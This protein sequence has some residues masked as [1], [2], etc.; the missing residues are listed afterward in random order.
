MRAMHHRTLPVFLALLALACD[1]PEP[2]SLEI[3][4]RSDL[5]A[6][7][8]AGARLVVHVAPA[9]S[10]IDAADALDLDAASLAMGA[11]A[12]SGGVLLGA[13]D[14]LLPG[15]YGVA[16]DLV[17]AGETVRLDVLA[18]DYVDEGA[19]QVV[20]TFLR[21]GEVACSDGAPCAE[22]P[23]ATAQ[24]IDGACFVI[25][26]ADHTDACECDVDGDCPAAEGCGRAVCDAHRCAIQPDDARC[27]ATESC[28]VD[29]H[30]D[31]VTCRGRAAG[32][33]CRGAANACDAPE[34]CPTAGGECPPDASRVV[35]EACVDDDSG[36]GGFC[37]VLTADAP[38]F[39]NTR[40]V[41]DEVCRVGCRTGRRVCTGTPRC[42][43][44]GGTIDDGEVCGAA[45]LC[46]GESVCRAGECVLGDP[47]IDAVCGDD[48][49]PDCVAA[50]RC[51]AE[52]RCEPS[53]APVGTACTL[54]TTAGAVVSPPECFT[55][56]C[57]SSGTCV[58]TPAASDP[59]CTGAEEDCGG[60]A[61][62]PH[63]ATGRWGCN[64]APTDALCITSSCDY[65][66]HCEFT[67]TM[68][69]GPYY[70]CQDWGSALC[71][72][73]DGTVAGCWDWGPAD[74][75]ANVQCTDGV[76]SGDETDADCGGPTCDIRCTT[77][78]RCGGDSDCDSGV[79]SGG[80]CA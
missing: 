40:C 24:C 42:E 23:C 32:D 52:G 38:L 43:L 80:T 58:A 18:V 17:R 46:R 61:C 60:V 21:D 59:S 3:V 4:L 49:A 73:D 76:Q 72:L 12:S 54:R 11:L 8:R 75:D 6:A 66:T 10:E 27:G 62:R 78:Q 74:C 5:S 55:H 35:G 41:A 77:G 71:R 70:E 29:L 9:G 68:D 63:R 16:L 1:A 79:C 15:R 36:I 50:P 33:V 34:L 56:T 28:A 65:R 31:T 47:T 69:R 44:D 48:P 26:D 2:G 64:A 25:R 45:Q 13:Y 22:A 51:S 57:S 37:D 39:C 30:C 67:D 7:E 20:F 19:Q 14:T 53:P